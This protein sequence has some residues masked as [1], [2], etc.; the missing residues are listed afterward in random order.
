MQPTQIKKFSIYFFFFCMQLLS[1]N[2]LTAATNIDFLPLTLKLL[3][4][5][6]I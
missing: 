4:E 5:S 6:G 3:P 1:D 2:T